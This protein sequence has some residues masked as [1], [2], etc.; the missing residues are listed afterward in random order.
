MNPMLCFYLIRLYGIIVQKS[1]A[2][3]Y[4]P[5]QCLLVSSGV[6]TYTEY[7]HKHT[8]AVVVALALG[9]LILV[10]T[11]TR[12]QAPTRDEVDTVP[13][14]QE[15]VETPDTVPVVDKVEEYVR[16]NISTLSPE[17]AVLGGTFYVTDVAFPEDGSAVVYYE[18]GHIALVADVRY[19]ITP[20]QSVQITSFVVR[21]GEEP[22]SLPKEKRLRDAPFVGGGFCKDQCGNG[23]CE[24]MVCMAEG[25]PCAESTASCPADCPSM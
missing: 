17:P 10:V 20:E 7:M 15:P 22:T 11:F 13:V 14:A 23:V 4:H 9:L 6:V 12:I 25:C 5:T 21:S 19:E 2:G 3:R 18:D 8:I 16:E 24:E 1:T